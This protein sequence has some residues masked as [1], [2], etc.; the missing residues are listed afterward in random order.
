M[1]EL[2]PTDQILNWW[3]S[4]TPEQQKEDKYKMIYVRL[5]NR[6]VLSKLNPY[7]IGKKLQG[8]TLLCFEKPPDF[9]HRHIVRVWLNMHN[10]QCNELLREEKK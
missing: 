9:C 3:K 5:Y 2:Y 6:D 4:L 1:P 10:I 7:A 8:K